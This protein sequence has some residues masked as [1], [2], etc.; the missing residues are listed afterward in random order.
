M[1]M[2]VN[3]KQFLEVVR[4]A[5]EGGEAARLAQ[6][7]RYRWRPRQLCSLLRNPDRDVRRV[8]AVVLGLVGDLACVGCLAR[9]LHDEDDQ[10]NE[11]A[12]H[13]LWSIWFRSGDPRASTPFRQGV[14]LLEA[15][16]YEEAIKKFR[17]ASR[18]DPEFSEAYNQCAIAHFFVSEW[19]RSIRDAKRALAL[20]P[21]HFGAVSGMGHCYTHLGKLDLALRCYR[22]TLAMNPRMSEIGRAIQG[23][24]ARLVPAEYRPGR[25]E[26]IRL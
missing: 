24:E 7:V 12:E 15:E 21:A 11:M 8:A 14:S 20:M 19:H 23:L 16:C 26:S 13:G 3:A 9:A 17:L 6:A 10:V 2:S 1:L 22:R 18:I 25:F 4:P 5:L